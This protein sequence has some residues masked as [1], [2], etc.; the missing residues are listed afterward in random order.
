MTRGHLAAVIGLG[1]V[2]VGGAIITAFMAGGG[3]RRQPGALELS[4]GE[5]RRLTLS[6]S[7][8]A[9]MDL[10]FASALRRDRPDLLDSIRSQPTFRE[11]QAHWPK[12]H[13]GDREFYVVEEDLPYTEDEFALYALRELDAFASLS[14]VEAL[15]SGPEPTPRKPLKDWASERDLDVSMLERTNASM[16][17]AERPV[18]IRILQRGSAKRP[19]V[20]RREAL[21]VGAGPGDQPIIVRRML[22]VPEENGR[23]IVLSTGARLGYSI[24]R[25]SFGDQYD[26]VKRHFAAATVSWSA[27]CDV[28]FDWLG[29]AADAAPGA[30]TLGTFVVRKGNCQGHLAMAFFPNWTGERHVLLVDDS[31]FGGPPA[32]PYDRTGIFRHEIGHVLGFLHEH[33]RPEANENVPDNQHFCTQDLP[34]G[35]PPSRRFL[36]DYDRQSVMH[37]LCGGKGSVAL[38]FSELDVKAVQKLYGTPHSP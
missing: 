24:D 9:L 22:S 34:A 17:P 7:E 28:A 26:L 15:D 16:L 27:I 10:S 30:P 25:T 1:A 4:S 19:I 14:R 31:Y 3:G 38:T 6:E 36:T 18:D 12:I 21:T 37:L 33:V 35:L 5:I 11:I 23:A 29:E 13:R 20:D 32:M 8:S 2:C